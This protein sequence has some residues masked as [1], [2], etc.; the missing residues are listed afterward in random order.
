MKTRTGINPD[1]KII[2][3][4]NTALSAFRRCPAEFGWKHI[5]HLVPKTES[6]SEHPPLALHYGIAWHTAMDTLYET[7]D[8]NATI[9]VFEKAAEGLA[10]DPKNRKTIG[11][12]IQDLH[13]YALIYENEL[14]HTELIDNE[15]LVNMPIALEDGWILEYVGAIDK[16][17]K[18]RDKL[19]VLDHKTLGYITM[20]T[21][22]A[23]ELSNQLTGYGVIIRDFYGIEDA[24]TVE[25]DI[26]GVTRTKPPSEFLRPE[27]IV[28]DHCADEWLLDI[29]TTAEMM[30]TAWK[31]GSL[32][33]YGH[34]ACTQF[35]RL[36]A[37]HQLCTAGPKTQPRAI[38]A[39]YAEL[40]WDPGERN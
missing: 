35:G 1:E 14:E 3:L 12:G 36:C 23:Y 29:K 11:R 15:I 7:G 16:L 21:P 31:L 28:N 2:R 5:L 19:K 40:P 4:D 10:E 32:P 39:G 30:L 9:T 34:D 18:V 38:E 27:I 37:Y 24:V 6:E 25:A 22:L 13:D 17:I 26:V 8:L 33:K 20:F